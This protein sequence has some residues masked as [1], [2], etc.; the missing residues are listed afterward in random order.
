M[1]MSQL[2]KLIKKDFAILFKNRIYLLMAVYPLGMS[3]TSIGLRINPESQSNQSTVSLFVTLSVLFVI[4]VG[5]STVLSVEEK[6]GLDILFRSLPIQQKQFILARYTTALAFYG[7]GLGL[8]SVVPL[9]SGVWL[10]H[11]TL[12]L[13]AYKVSF[14]IATIMVS[15]MMPAYFKLGYIKTSYVGRFVYMFIVMGPFFY[16]QLPKLTVGQVMV[17]GLASLI[18]NGL[19]HSLWMAFVLG[20]FL[21]ISIRLSISFS[22]Q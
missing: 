11:Q 4:Y 10:S 13:E 18:Q 20:F 15:L 17:S 21:M 16:V 12:Y 2:F 5:K 3:F 1:A 9:L 14:W 22:A 6:E 19:N 8:V 7:I